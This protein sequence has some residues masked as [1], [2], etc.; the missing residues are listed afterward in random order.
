M[1]DNY[2][3]PTA[4][5]LSKF[6]QS[7]NKMILLEA[8]LWLLAL[9]RCSTFSAHVTICEQ[10]IKDNKTMVAIFFLSYKLNWQC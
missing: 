9:H 1:L 6:E 2:K 8:Q 5:H 10:E 4:Y 3:C 7:W